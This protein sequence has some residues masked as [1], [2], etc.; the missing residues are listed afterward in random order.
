M[1]C[2]LHHRSSRRCA[3]SCKASKTGDLLFYPDEVS[4]SGRVVRCHPHRRLGEVASCV[5]VQPL[6]GLGLI[7]ETFVNPGMGHVRNL[8]DKWEIVATE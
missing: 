7:L 8:G 5:G 2:R 1:I 3:E 4:E 6:G